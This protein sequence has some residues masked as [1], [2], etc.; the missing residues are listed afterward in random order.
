VP[1]S[2][3]VICPITRRICTA[4]ERAVERAKLENFHRRAPMG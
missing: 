1:V 3:I 2:I 4:F